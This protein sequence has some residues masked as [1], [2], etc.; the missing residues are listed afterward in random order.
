MAAGAVA[1]LVRDP[2]VAGSWGVCPS[3]LLGF[4][5]PG[6]GGLRGASELLHGDVASAWAYN[7]LVVVG[8]PLVLALIVRWFVDAARGRE[9]WSPGAVTVSVT[10]GLLLAFAVLRNV[11][12]LAPYLGPL[13]V[14]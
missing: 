9:P 1:L 4:A 13:A 6:C 10:V 2:H 3:L 5:C 11:P 8:A 14:P 12:A 7:P